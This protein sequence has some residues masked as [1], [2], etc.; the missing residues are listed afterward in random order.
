MILSESLSLYD[1]YELKKYIEKK[2]LLYIA[3]P[4]SYKAADW[5]K[6]NKIKLIKIGSGET[7]NI[8]FIKH[9][10]SFKTPMIVSTGMNSLD[11]IKKTVNLINKNQIPHV[12]L[13]CVNLYPT[14]YHLIRLS[15]M[16]DM[17]KIFKKSIIGYSDHTVGNSIP[18]AAIALGAKVV[19]KHFVIDKKTKGPD[20]SCSMDHS[21]ASDL[22][23]ATNNIFNAVSGRS[24]FLKEEEVTRKFIIL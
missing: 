3:T 21:E 12:L 9:V 23:E 8:P 22:L 11:T 24:K 17:K 6:E 5:L 15:R 1:E 19:E 4:F 2:N 10:C 16:L 7:N 14:N 18:L 13:H 20:V